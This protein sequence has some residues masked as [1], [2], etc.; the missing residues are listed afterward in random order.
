M[1]QIIRDTRT[2][3]FAY[4]YHPETANIFNSIGQS[5][6]VASYVAKYQKVAE[7]QPSILLD[8]IEQLS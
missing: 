2:I 8:S 1:L 4:A 5:S 6:R 3:V 7:N